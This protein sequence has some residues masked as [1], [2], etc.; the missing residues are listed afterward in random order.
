VDDK[1][2]FPE[3]G[4]HVIFLSA[5]QWSEASDKLAILAE[6]YQTKQVSLVV[7]NSSGAVSK[8]HLDAAADKEFDLFWNGTTLHLKSGGRAW[9]VQD[10]TVSEVSKESAANPLSQA[11]LEV[12]RWEA[13]VHAAGGGNDADF[14]CQSCSL[15]AL[16]REQSVNK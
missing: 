7:W 8:F 16:P 11:R 4:T 2:V 1:P 6:N 9:R 10:D 14:W 3:A 13:M 15:T 5:P 12:K